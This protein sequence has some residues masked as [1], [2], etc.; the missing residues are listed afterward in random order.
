VKLL[1]DKGANTEVTRN[2]GATALYVSAYNGQLEVVK[3]LLEKGAVL[4]ARTNKGN[5]IAVDVALKDGH[6]AV[7]ELFSPEIAEMRIRK[8][9][10]VEAC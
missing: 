8:V 5:L 4:E 7:V 3:L 9:W 2:T 10:L 6:K 1:L